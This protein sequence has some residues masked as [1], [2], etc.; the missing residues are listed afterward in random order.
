MHELRPIKNPAVASQGWV[1][2]MSIRV[3]R[4]RNDRNKFVCDKRELP[5]VTLAKLLAHCI[6]ARDAV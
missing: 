4:T 5:A 2:G 1:L 3:N 6:S